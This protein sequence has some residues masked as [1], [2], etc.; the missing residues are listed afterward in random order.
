MRSA[1]LTL[2]ICMSFGLWAKKSNLPQSH[3]ATFVESTSPAE[4]MIRAAG[5]GKKTAQAEED[6]LKAAVYFIL[7][8]GTDPLLKTD[9]AKSRFRMMEEE[10][11]DINNLRK[12][13]TWEGTG[14]LSR[15]KVGKQIKVE[16]MFRI[17]RENIYKDLVARGILTKRED[18]AEQVGLPTIMVLPETRKGESPLE[19]LGKSLNRHGATVLKSYLTARGYDVSIPEAEEQLSGIRQAISGI[20]GIEQDDAYLLALSIGSDIYVKYNISIS[21]RYV[22]GTLVKKAS[23][24]VE[25]YE[26]TTGKSLGAETGYSRE[27]PTSDEVVAE[28]ALH[29]AVDKVLERITSY[30]QKAIER[31]NEY[32]V[33]FNL[34]GF[35]D[36][37]EA[38]EVSFAIADALDEVCERVK[39]VTA[40][41]QTLDYIVWSKHKDSLRLYRALKKAFRSQSSAKLR[42]VFD[43]R[44]FLIFE[45][46]PE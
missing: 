14:L 24:T 27:R 17:H 35:T 6:A 12:Y 31:G 32:K 37:D 2:A 16:K 4:W 44:K 21:Q 8:M 36:E 19:A 9:E 30:W 5:Y 22:G 38:E 10:F 41:L 42:K 40:T 7:Y 3:E 20:R 1:I 26:T 45:V 25:A 43:T 15:V 13:V 11:F 34:V 28:E 39:K 29:D 33:T 46:S 23:V 18:L